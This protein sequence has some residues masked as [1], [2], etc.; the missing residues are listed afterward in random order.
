[1]KKNAALLLMIF[2]YSVANASAEWKLKKENDHLKVFTAAQEQS[3]NK[4]IRVEC[5]VKGKFSQVVA[6]LFDM[7]RQKE[8]V[9]N[10]K[11]SKLLKRIK[12]NEI[13][14]YS[15]INV[16]WPCDNRDFISHLTITQPSP[17]SVVITSRAEPDFIPEK[18]GIVR[19]KNSSATWTMTSLGNNQIRIEYII[20]FDPSGY[21]P[22]WL[23]NLFVVKGPYETF[24]RLQQRMNM[25]AYKN[26]HFDFIKE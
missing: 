8:W 18:D 24:D 20:Q 26:A 22:A 21:V 9:F 5:T 2:A 16:P 15:E 6:A 13:I 25:S 11:S 3:A 17:K 4:S 7:D 10:N 14:Y 12:E 23:T 1:M 19:I